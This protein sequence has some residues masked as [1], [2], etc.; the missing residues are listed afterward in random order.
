MGSG[1]FYNRSIVSHKLTGLTDF[2]QSFRVLLTSSRIV[3]FLRGCRHQRVDLEIQP[4]LAT[5]KDP[6]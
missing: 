1:V 5:C 4:Y 6:Q 3:C 2:H